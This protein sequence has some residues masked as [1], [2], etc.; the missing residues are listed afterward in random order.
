M[1]NR[2]IVGKI[3]SVKGSASQET[4]SWMVPVEKD[5]PVYEG[6]IIVTHKK[7]TVQIRFHDNSLLT[8]GENSRLVIDTYVCDPEHAKKP[9]RCFRLPLGRIRFN[10]GRMVD[11]EAEGMNIK[12]LLFYRS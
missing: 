5:S 12:T 10:S 11:S 3:E 1:K 6:S 4:T 2:P 7:S 8:Q 9:D